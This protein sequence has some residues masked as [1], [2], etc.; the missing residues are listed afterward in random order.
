V[1]VPARAIHHFLEDVEFLVRR[2][3]QHTN[4]EFRHFLLGMGC[5]GAIVGQVRY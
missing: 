3:D 4:L 5:P 2:G 1:D